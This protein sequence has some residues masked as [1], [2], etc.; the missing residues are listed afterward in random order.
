MSSHATG[1]D[2]EV[3]VQLGISIAHWEEGESKRGV[4]VALDSHLLQVSEEGAGPRERAGEFLEPPLETV[5]AR[6]G[7]N[8]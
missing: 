7:R 6:D 8:V 5:L 2:P 3:L 1:A 4:W